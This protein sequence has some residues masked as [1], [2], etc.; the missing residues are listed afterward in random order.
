VRRKALLIACVALLA[1][2]AGASA[3]AVL[4]ASEPARGET[5][6]RTPDRVVFE[7]SE[8]VEASFG[9]LRVFDSAGAQ[10]HSGEVFRPDGD[11]K[12]IA[13]RLDS[14]L[15]DGTYIA[16]YRVVSAD[17]HP[18]SGGSIFSIGAATGTDKTVGELLEQD[19]VGKVTS[20]TFG[21]V[22]GLRYAAIA[23]L[24]GGL[25]FMFFMWPPAAGASL[26]VP[27]ARRFLAVVALGGF[28]VSAAGIVLQGA[29]AA[30]TSFWS[31]LDPDVVG[32]VLKTRFG[33]VWCLDLAAWAVAIAVLL[34]P[35]FAFRREWRGRNAF[36]LALLAVASAFLVLS[37][38][39]SGHAISQS[40]RGV[41][42]PA[43]ALHVAAM[44]VWVG[45]LAAL[46]F[47]VPVAT[48]QLPGG[49]RS[50]LL[51]GALLRFSPV[52]LVCVSVVLLTGAVQGYVHIRELDNLVETAF[53][54]AVLIKAILIVP[55][56][57]LGAW[58]R[59]RGIPGVQRAAETGETPGAAGIA[60]RRV[61]R[62]EV[63]VFV[64][65][66]GVTAAL[67]SYA[68][69]TARDAGPFSTTESMGP[70][71]VQ[72]TVDP[73]EAGRNE[74]HIYLFETSTGAQF[75]KTKEMRVALELPSK[76]IGPLAPEV[77]K[78]GPGH[79]TVPAADFV[80]GGDWTVAL[81]ARVSEFDEY[82]AEV[83][84]PIE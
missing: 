8:P 50:Q 26:L 62:F 84:V 3:H 15:P 71:E 69:A 47:L 52:A 19:E 23:V 59:R 41:L 75:D 16:T 68:P 5:L 11:S 53:G 54:R 57:G 42:I 9:A 56:I 80:P 79:Y 7:F 39:L 25:A 58:N 17:S 32:E 67:V 61:L 14:D 48:R 24:V 29:T 66:L 35:G 49:A 10:V 77:E 72:L 43:N 74:M 40:P 27:R 81:S 36:Y 30:G 37:P 44:S 6:E 18:I 12:Q 60:I 1:M 34:A 73:A 20:T 38:S 31:A 82:T 70:L 63:A 28:L 13:V 78:T 76:E 4:E 65:V 55:L 21:V 33:T 64:A 46:L 22:R 83:E 2:P 45:G 51:A